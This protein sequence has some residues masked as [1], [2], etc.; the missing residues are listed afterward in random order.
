MI[1]SSG[2]FSGGGG[3][4]GS[5]RDVVFNAKLVADPKNAQVLGGIAK[6]VEDLQRKMNNLRVGTAGGGS[7]RPGAGGRAGGA[8]LVGS[9]IMFDDPAENRRQTQ[10]FDR[11]IREEQRI[12]KQNAAERAKDLRMLK[13]DTK[14]VM[15]GMIGLSRA[16]VLF[17]VSSEE[18]LEKAVRALAKFEGAI[19]GVKG[20]MKLSEGLGGL[21]GRAA[22]RLGMAAGASGMGLGAAGIAA[23]V[24]VLG[25]GMA[26][27]DQMQYMRTGQIGAYSRGHASTAASLA[28]SGFGQ[29]IRPTQGFAGGIGNGLSGGLG[30]LL[31]YS[32][33]YG[34]A[35]SQ[36]AA[37]NQASSAATNI[38]NRIRANQQLLASEQQIL[39]VMEREAA[40]SRGITA[41]AEGRLQSVAFAYQGLSGMD[42]RGVNRLRDKIQKDPSKVSSR[43][44]EYFL[45]YASE[46]MGK[47]IGNELRQRTRGY[48]EGGGFGH[49][50]EATSRDARREQSAANRNLEWK[51]EITIQLKEDNSRLLDEAVPIIEQAMKTADDDLRKELQEAVDRIMEGQ[52]QLREQSMGRVNAT[53]NSYGFGN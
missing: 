30:T 17:G 9:S 36:R 3:G 6:Q 20:G 19:A 4:G 45:P 32:G 48:F 53:T 46:S 27:Y 12:I 11:A 29:M 51:R 13:K 26:I 40:V 16:F 2:R 22:P 39:S 34:A 33:A 42:K 31:Q 28:G 25:G 21:L 23:G 49:E 10:F 41:A 5:H 1:M 8:S 43:A 35:D 15:E 52:R 44:L 14:D 24:G 37:G 47:T 38:E 18:N 50:L 7:G